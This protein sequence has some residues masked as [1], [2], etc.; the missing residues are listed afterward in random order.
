MKEIMFLNQ[1]SRLDNSHLELV[2]DFLRRDPD[3]APS[4]ASGRLCTLHNDSGYRSPN[5][6]ACTTCGVE[7]GRPVQFWWENVHFETNLEPAS[8]L[9]EFPPKFFRKYHRMI[10]LIK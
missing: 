1:R 6:Y 9:A 8:V 7:I 10:Q 2:G 4:Q 3:I 5:F